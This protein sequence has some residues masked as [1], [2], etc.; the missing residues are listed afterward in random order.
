[1][2][3]TTSMGVA[4]FPEDGETTRDLLESADNTL[5]QAKRSGRNRVTVVAVGDNE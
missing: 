1:M 4:Q 5:Y 3:I 2:K